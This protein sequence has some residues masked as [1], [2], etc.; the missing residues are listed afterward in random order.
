MGVKLA[1]LV[2]TLCINAKPVFPVGTVETAVAS[3]LRRPGV[4]AVVVVEA[5]L[6][7]HKAF[8]GAVAAGCEIHSV[9]SF[10]NLGVK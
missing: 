5:G 8:K 3:I 10:L 7:L 4:A 2:G 6:A 9:A 1:W